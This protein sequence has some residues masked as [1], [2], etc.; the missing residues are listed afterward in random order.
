MRTEL[1]EA[2]AELGR[3]LLVVFML[4]HAQ[5]VV[6]HEHLSVGVRAGTDANGG[7][8]QLL[9]DRQPD[10]RG[11]ALDHDGEAPCVLQR[12]RVVQQGQ[13]GRCGAAL[14]AK[15]ANDRVGLRG[16]ADVTHHSD[17]TAHQGAE[18]S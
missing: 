18:K 15:T 11:D 14:G 10:L 4:H 8:L 6:V 9:R 16:E 12:A 5:Q 1:G 2:L 13:R 3:D 17:A 7:D